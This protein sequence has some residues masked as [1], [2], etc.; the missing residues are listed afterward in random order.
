MRTVITPEYSLMSMY[1]S[2]A[3]FSA[4]REREGER[5]GLESQNDTASC[6]KLAGRQSSPVINKAIVCVCV[7]VCVCVF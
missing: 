2:A 3:H 7:C 4:P 5:L 1:P 6:V